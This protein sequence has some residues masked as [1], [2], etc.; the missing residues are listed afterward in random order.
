MV[1]Y[2][3][4]PQKQKQDLK[5]PEGS[6]MGGQRGD[7]EEVSLLDLGRGQQGKVLP[8]SRD[9]DFRFLQTAADSGLWE[10][11]AVWPRSITEH[12]D[13]IHR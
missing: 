4:L 10:Y 9:P 12:Q 1:I 13:S 8:A 6:R 11:T 7:R 2:S 5:L 3:N